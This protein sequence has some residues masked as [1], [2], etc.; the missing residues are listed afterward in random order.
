MGILLLR[1]VSSHEYVIFEHCRCGERYSAVT[2]RKNPLNL[3]AKVAT[4]ETKR[5]CR[6]SEN[7]AKWQIHKLRE[8]GVGGAKADAYFGYFG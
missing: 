2:E 8:N 4:W 1:K 6:K 5:Q 7:S 3:V